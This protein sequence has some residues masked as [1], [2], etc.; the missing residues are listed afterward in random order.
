M[1]DFTTLN[2]NYNT[3]TDASPTFTGTA[4][5]FGGSAG[6]NELRWGPSSGTSGSTASASW[7]YVTRP[8]SGT[9]TVP[10]LWAFTADTTGNQV[11]TYTG[12]N[13]NAKVLRWNWDNT[14]TFAAASQFSAFGDN[15]H[16]APSPGTQP[17][18]QSGSPIVN[19]SGDTSNTSY[20]KYNAY[21]SGVTA[22]GSQETPSAG[23]VGTNPAATTGTAGSV[24]TTAGDWLN[25]H[26]AWQGVC[27]GG[28]NI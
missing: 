10:Q 4:L 24:T 12:S 20:L 7:P 26:A 5:A 19:G 18:G 23:S 11:L 8:T 25:T 16:T 27:K 13:A 15:T 9:A 21:G 28:G 2:L 22:G 14:G 1:S 3:N 17:G 6:A